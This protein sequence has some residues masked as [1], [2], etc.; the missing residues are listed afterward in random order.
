MW[1]TFL[2]FCFK[3]CTFGKKC[4]IIVDKRVFSLFYYIKR[5]RNERTKS[6]KRLLK[7][8]EEQHGGKS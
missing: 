5:E 2:F 3:H 1:K 6:E 8:K 7:G 4:V